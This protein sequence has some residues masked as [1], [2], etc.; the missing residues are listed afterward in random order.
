MTA[1][2][3]RPR[4]D[5][6][7]QTS[8]TVLLDVTRQYVHRFVSIAFR[9]R[10]PSSS[11][12]TT[13]VVIAHK[14]I[15]NIIVLLVLCRAE[16]DVAN[17]VCDASSATCTVS[18][19]PVTKRLDTRHRLIVQARGATMRLGCHSSCS[20]IFSLTPCIPCDAGARRRIV[21]TRHR[22]EEELGSCSSH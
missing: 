11:H 1:E 7:F 18:S 14:R 12:I 15:V 8:P 22:H 20:A 13:S 6:E 10:S 5:V 19:C 16:A 2:V 17:W 21:Q 9:S 4:C 3:N